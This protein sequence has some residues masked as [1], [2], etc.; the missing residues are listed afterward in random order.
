MT[1]VTSPPTIDLTNLW[2]DLQQRTMAGEAVQ[3][4]YPEAS[5]PHLMGY[6]AGYYGYLWSRV[7]AQDMFTRFEKEGVLNPKTG[8]A[9]RHLVL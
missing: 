4:G 1:L 5:F 9:Y 2:Y 3:T 6:D 8:M 7:M